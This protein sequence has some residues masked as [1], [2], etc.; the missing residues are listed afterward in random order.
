MMARV[1]AVGIQIGASTHSQLQLMT[2]VSFRTM[3]ATARRPQK[4]IPPAVVLFLSLFMYYLQYYFPEPLQ[5]AGCAGGSD[6]GLQCEDPAGRVCLPALSATDG[7][8][9]ELPVVR[10][11]LRDVIAQRHGED[12]AVSGLVGREDGLRLVGDHGV[13]EL[14]VLL[15]YGL[16]RCAPALAVLRV[17]RG[18]DVGQLVRQQL[19]GGA[20]GRLGRDA[21]DRR[22]AVVGK[23]GQA[24]GGAVGLVRRSGTYCATYSTPG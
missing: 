9:G 3:K 21:D 14:V 4:P 19:R 22:A 2:P 1:M 13:E 17:L 11:G 7:A 15:E 23:D 20:D 12:P 18:G 8:G 10:R 5:R 24:V 6:V 16:R